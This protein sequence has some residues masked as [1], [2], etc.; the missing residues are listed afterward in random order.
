MRRFFFGLVYTI[1]QRLSDMTAQKL[2]QQV[3]FIL[4]TKYLLV[5]TLIH[6]L[7]YILHS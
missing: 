7:I 4:F 5:M 3:S 2:S 1:L 6:Q